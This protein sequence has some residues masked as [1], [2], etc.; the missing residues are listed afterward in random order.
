MNERNWQQYGPAVVTANG[1][2]NG[3]ISVA[4][5]FG[6]YV[7]MKVALSS[8][9]QTTLDL[10]VKE[11]TSKT[12][13]RLGPIGTSINDYFKLSLFLVADGASIRAAYQ[14]MRQ[15]DPKDIE[16]ATYSREPIVAKRSILVDK[17]GEYLEFP[18]PVQVEGATFEITGG[19]R[20]DMDGFDATNP[21]SVMITGS[22]DGT[23]TGIKRGVIITSANAMKVDGSAV[24]Q[25]ISATTLPLPTNASTSTLQTVANTILSSIDS[26]LTSPIAV[27]GTVNATNPSV[28]TT[29]TPIPASATMVGGSDGTNLRAFKVSSTGVLSVDGSATTQPISATTLPLPTNAS[30]SAL[31]TTGNTSLASIDSKLTSPLTVSV[32]NFPAT[33]AVTQSGIWS[34]GRTWTLT[35]GTDSVSSVQSGTW[36]VNITNTSIPVTQGTS[37]WVVSGTITANLGTI[38]GVATEATL[39][40]L[41]TKIP[42]GLTVTATRLLVDSSGVVQPI[43]A[44]VLPLPS[45]AS[46]S[47]NQTNGSQK[48]QLVDGSG[49]VIGSTSNALDVNIKSGITLNV[50]LDHTTDNILI[51]G[52]DGTTDRKIKTNASGEVS[53]NVISSALPTNASTSAL[54]TTGNTSLASIDTKT[55]ALGQA[56]AASSVPVV[57]TASQLTTL[58][59]LSTITANI[60][61]TNGLAL[62]TSVNSLLKPSSTLAAVTTLGSITS[63]VNIAAA[64]LPL[65]SGAATSANQISVIGSLTGG[66]S[67]TNSLLTGGVFNTTLPTLTN[68][69]QAALQLDSSGRLLVDIGSS[70]SLS[71]N[72][73]QFGGNNVVTGTGAS[74]L[75]IPRFT[76]SNDSNI[77]STQSGTWNITNISGTVSL[78]TGA[79]TSA[80]QTTGNTSLASI[81]SKLVDGFGVATAAL[82]VAAILGNASGVADFGAG[83]TSAQTQ[84]VVFPTD[85]TA[86]PAKLQ[87]GSGNAITSTSGALDVNIKGDAIQ[88]ETGIADKTAFTYGT[89]VQ[90]PVGGVF[91][92]TAPS[93]TAGTT[94]AL[95][96]TAQRGLHV[97]LRDASGVEISPATSALQ[98][99]GNTS[100]ASMD[101]KTPALGQALAAASVPV[102]LTA[103]Q[104]TTLTPLSTVT[105]N[106]GTTNGLALDTSVNSLLK[107]ASTL[108]AVTSLTQFNGN[109]ISTNTGVRD[110]GTLRVTV[111]TN[112][113]VPISVATLPLP[114][115]AST[116]A[117][118]TTGN[119]S[120]A[121][122]A[123]NTTMTAQGAATAGL[124]GELSLGATTTAAPT[125][126][127][128]TSNP[129][130]LTT[131][132]ALRTDS[133]ATVQPIS[134][135]SLPL[136]TGASTS[137]NQ[138]NGNQKTQLVDS[139]GANIDT[140][141]SGTGLNGLNVVQ[142]ATQFVLSSVNSTTTQLAASATF[143][144]LIET[145]FNQ[146][147]ISLLLTSDQPGTFHIK[148]YIDLA[149]TRIVS[150]WVFS[151]AAGVPFSRAFS[152]NGNYF[153]LTFQNTGASATTTLNINTAYGT[154]P[155]VTNLG[156][157]PISINEVNGSMLSLGQATMS[158]SLPVTFAS[159]Q[160]TLPISIGA[161][162]TATYTAVITS[163]AAVAAATDIF[164]ITGSA[165]KTVRITKIAISGTSTSGVRTSVV[166]IKRSTAN[167]GGTS[168]TPTAVPLD[169]TNAAATAVVRSYTANP[170]VGTSV[171]SVRS[172]KM[173]FP[174]TATTNGIQPFEFMLG[175]EAGQQPITLRGTTEVIA[176]NL[177]GA[178]IT[179]GSFD[180]YIEWT[181]V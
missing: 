35:S 76:I 141:N 52:N 85:Q 136:P 114:T 159:N 125:Y 133:S 62:D 102:V 38:A 44:T 140:L 75:G 127:T 65:P 20:V 177:N 165:T 24:V 156:Y 61:T 128:A 82:R 11:V 181:E 86:I 143:T 94:G 89:S 80:L 55:P 59:P 84:R 147:T 54:Q 118:Q 66:T 153:N 135:T 145:V 172:A 167:T 120:L 32:N 138:T 95:R 26:K 33:Q 67:A 109:A 137:A 3:Y 116:S 14:S 91:Q 161:S 70:V 169:S 25:P 115:G 23:K 142:T 77:L 49:N 152:A 146:Q 99:T 123:T 88:I 60:G 71:Q 103:A 110:S 16:N 144:G 105:A 170:T 155:A 13:V 74:G 180:L 51:Y 106:I 164:T 90:Q 6:L 58:T 100:L 18:L 171:G 69:Q 68:G 129:L 2:D 130:S 108:A 46:T 43:S 112:D 162:T 119:A 87:D 179:G 81:D 41:N 53:V 27:T 1:D 42:S 154:L 50:S 113:L 160:S 12:Q 28:S 174:T 36:N 131:A 173:D 48:T 21:D 124:T 157:S 111:A 63:T 22:S 96:L 168:T 101:T 158:A 83:T 151:I 126:T 150:D 15:I 34:T 7:K 166:V 9:T 19:L 176:I 93:L 98:T 10:E 97:N 39:S 29:G 139:T 175:G 78:P 132:G 73:A 92:D 122:I 134:A 37:P 17:Y 121:T 117:L 104:L 45:G 79:A 40:A 56:L 5:T 8:S 148:Q 72:V 57:L 47:A 149:G 31:Q 107:P 4:N 64:S 30:T 178:T 163:V